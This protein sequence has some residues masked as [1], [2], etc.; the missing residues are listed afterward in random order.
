MKLLFP[1]FFLILLLGSCESPPSEFSKIESPKKVNNP[2]DK[3]SQL[4][5]VTSPSDSMITGTLQ[6]YE[7]QG[8]QWIKAANPHPITLGKTGLAWGSGVH[9]EKSDYYKKEGDGKSPAG[10]FTFGTAFGYAPKEEVDFLKLDYVPLTEI[11]QCIED[12]ES[13]YYNQIVNDANI[14]SDWNST[15]FMLRKDDLYKWGVFVNHNTPAKAQRGSC[16]F[17]HLWRG[18]DRHTAGCTAMTEENILSLIKWLDP[19]KNPMLVQVTEKDYKR[20]QKEYKLP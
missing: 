12:S 15:D 17:F 20:Y 14:K 11:T 4:V 18:P 9:E 13:K 2:F 1:L 7:K 3:S 19:A 8:E 10:I 16:I 6:R 5:I